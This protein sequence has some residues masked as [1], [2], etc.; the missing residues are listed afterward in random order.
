MKGVA[1]YK[2]REILFLF[3]VIYMFNEFN[4]RDSFA[5][6]IGSSN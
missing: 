3:S 6:V 4:Y 2:Q 1:A 5:G